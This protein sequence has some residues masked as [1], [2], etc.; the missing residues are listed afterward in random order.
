MLDVRIAPPSADALSIPRAGGA[1]RLRR[2]AGELARTIDDHRAVLDASGLSGERLVAVVE[3]L[4]LGAYRFS[5]ATQ[6]TPGLRLI[7]LA[8]AEDSAAVSRGLRNARAGAWARTL[9]DT[10][11]A[12]KTPAWLATTA[13]RVLTPLGVD[14]AAHDEVWLTSQ[15][16]GGVLAVGAG[17]VAPPR[18]IEATWKPRR[19]TAG[20]HVV[21]VGK[22]ITFD[23]G[24][25][26]LKPGD[27][28]RTMYTDM[29]GGAAVLGALRLVAENEVPIRVT[30]LV[31][32]AENSI[33][34]TAMRPSD[35]ITHYGGRTSEIL[36]TDA[37][38][39]I[40]LADALAYAAAKLRPTALVDIATL[41]GAM[42]IALGM[43]TG[44]LF[45]TDDR[46][47]GGLSRAG[48][49]AGEPLWRM[50]L[51]S[52]YAS[53]LRS[54]VA[55]AN[56]APGSPGAITAALFLQPFTAGLPWAHLDVAGPGRS[57]EDDGMFSKGATG[58]GARLLARWIESLA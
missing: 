45:A 12:T 33:S 6:P 55:D 16:F 4:V 50:P 52:D 32:A 17:S 24:G 43:R 36:N 34:G 2:A 18:L 21:L 37:E 54:E 44:G 31:P 38:G 25:I 27:G 8:G 30:A 7:E 49:A 53:T 35:V 29:S 14:V 10:R 19:S 13:A 11:S 39:R 57:A 56:N 28:M 48:D 23:T 15:G 9:A 46:L 20:V 3:G 47:A 22:G 1:D 40:V 58:F 51:E 41:T 5:L 42:K 26:N